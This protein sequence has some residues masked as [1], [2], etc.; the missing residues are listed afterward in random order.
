M[1]GNNYLWLLFDDYLACFI[2]LLVIFGA[3]PRHAITSQTFQVA[4]TITPGC[5]VS[6]GTLFGTLDFGTHPSNTNGNIN[7]SLTPNTSLTL[8]CTPGTV[9]SMSID[10]GN[11]YTTSRNVKQ[12]GFATLLPYLLY[13]DS[14]HTIPIAL[15]QNVSVSYSNSNNIILPIYGVLQFNGA[16]NPSSNYTDVLTVTLSW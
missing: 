3:L 8:A 11:N 16:N 10:G 9:L 12:S 14:A 2:V 4:A 6:G 5:I 7:A 15:N 13:A 1:S